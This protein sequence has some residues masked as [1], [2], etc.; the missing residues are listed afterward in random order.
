MAYRIT[1]PALPSEFEGMWRLNHKIFSE[2]LGQHPR[3]ESGSLTDKFH[4]K[5]IY[6]IA[7]SEGR[8]VGM[9]AAHT[10]APFSAV[11]HFGEVMEN[12]VIPGK[13]GEIRL[14]AI[15]RDLRGKNALA[16][17]LCG[18]ILKELA[19]TGTEKILITGVSSQKKFYENIGF[20]A[21]GCPIREG[22][23]VF[24]PMVAALREIRERNR[25]IL[26]R[27]DHASN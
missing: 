16:L 25:K 27:I 15:E 24:Y 7:L 2:E 22:D 17:R 3:R 1:T 26:E 6:K 10:Q 8:V 12:E 4:G 19:R 23:A 20:R 14:L 13:T 18:A 21:L 9:V 11:A 5:N